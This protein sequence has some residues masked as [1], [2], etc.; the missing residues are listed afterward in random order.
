MIHT[1]LFYVLK[2]PCVQRSSCRRA[3]WMT[4]MVLGGGSH[5][6]ANTHALTHIH[7]SLSS[8]PGRTLRARC[9]PHNSV[10]S[11]QNASLLAAE[12][13]FSVIGADRDCS[14]TLGLLFLY[15]HTC[16]VQ[17]NSLQLRG[18]TY[19]SRGILLKMNICHIKK[20]RGQGDYCVHRCSSKETR[21]LRSCW[22]FLSL[23][24]GSVWGSSLNFFRTP[25]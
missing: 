15:V 13:C 14:G 16:R 4:L 2:W 3:S 12:Y 24:G 23:T 11:C 19:Q 5:R 9:P 25:R 21:V 18:G 22:G 6:G 20:Q 7:T 1:G 17:W 10:L 8:L